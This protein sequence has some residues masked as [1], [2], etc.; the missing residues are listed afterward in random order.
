MFNTNLNFTKNTILST[1]Y[2]SFNVKVNNVVTNK[3]YDLGA[4]VISRKFV[5]D[6]FQQIVALLEIFRENA[7]PSFQHL[8]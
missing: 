7:T 4:I 3:I 8:H 5:E 2:F 6:L 1:E